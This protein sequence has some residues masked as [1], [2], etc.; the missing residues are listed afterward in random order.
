MTNKG[1]I[2][3][4]DNCR[5]LEELDARHCPKLIDVRVEKLFVETCKISGLLGSIH[6][7][8]GLYR[9]DP[10]LFGENDLNLEQLMI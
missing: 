4:S 7:P 9:L 3:L 6:T 10:A 5:K 1:M 8:K 2:A